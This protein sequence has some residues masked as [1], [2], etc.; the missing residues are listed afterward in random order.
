[1][2]VLYLNRLN[3]LNL[4]RQR[5]QEET[6]TRMN[7]VI[8]TSL[9]GIIV[10]D[11][12]GLVIE[13]SQA[14][15]SI[16]GY[17]AHEAIGQDIALLVIPQGDREAHRKAMKRVTRGG[18][19]HVI[20]AGRLR[21]EAMRKDGTT[22]PSELSIQTAKL[23]NHRIYVAF[24]RDVTSRVTAE[25]D[26]VAARD[27]ALAG[28]RLKTDFLAT[29]SHE[30]RTPLNG[31]LGNLSLM[32]DTA[33][34]ARQ[35][36]YVHDMETSGRLL[37]NHISDVLDITRYEAGKLPISIVP[38][39]IAVVMQDIIDSLTAMAEASHTTLSYEWIGQDRNWVMSDP[40][41]VQLVL[42]NV[43]SNAVKFTNGGEVRVTSEIVKP[44]D[45]VQFCVHDTGPGMS[46][47][48]IRHV[49]DDF[50]TGNPAYN[51]KVGGTGL[52]LSIAKRFVTA[53]GGS[54]TVES[55]LGQ[56]SLFTVTFPMPPAAP[57]ECASPPPTRATTVPPQD[58]RA[59]L[60]IEDNDIIR[61]LAG[62]R[63]ES[64]GH[65]V[66]QA[67]NGETGVSVA[68]T[69]RF[70]LIFMDI[71]MPVMDGRTAA[72]LIREGHGKSA[73]TP[74]VAL[75]AHALPA[76]LASF[77]ADDGM[78]AT[79]TKPLTKA[80]L[81]DVLRKTTEACHPTD[82][83]SAYRSPAYA[84]LKQRFIAETDSFITWA[85]TPNLSLQDIADEAHKAAGSA[86]TFQVP[87][88][89][90]QLV[91]LTTAARAGDRPEVTAQIA[92]LRRNWDKAQQML[93]GDT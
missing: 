29:M 78:V 65:T 51:R 59:I 66:T 39:N 30:I 38:M 76:D 77:V 85:Q 60:V 69:T 22:F 62:E 15:E 42:I 68:R 43:V 35:E 67:H 63:L 8:E 33:L 86:S 14:A 11:E 17:T 19:T 12:D 49:F 9:D 16:F 89:A 13:F 21:M 40:D 75:T 41:R 31:L 61:A 37:M 4:Q 91:A 84:K 7:T 45:H 64:V 32:Q 80:G 46:A 6:V 1:M 58:P 55:K 2:S 48:L 47:D 26:L 93:A 36:R 54:I 44:S 92:T 79:L 81:L 23:H 88:F 56:G 53:L 50:V 34:T 83:T 20:G 71:S 28:E 73:K 57:P 24:L 52:G 10:T 87:D 82:D 70:D 25:S 27:A 3:F 72:R 5:A 74:I 18:A 90:A